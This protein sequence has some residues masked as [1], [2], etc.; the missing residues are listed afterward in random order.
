[1]SADGAGL[2]HDRGTLSEL[3]GPK[4]ARR[5]PWW[6]P[7]DTKHP[8]LREGIENAAEQ[9]FKLLAWPGLALH[10]GELD[11]KLSGYGAAAATGHSSDASGETAALHSGEV[12]DLGCPPMKLEAFLTKWLNKGGAE[13]ANKDSFLRDFCDVLGVEGPPPAGGD[14]AG[15]AYGFEH[16]VT[17]VDVDGTRRPGFIDLYKEGCFILEAK[18][19][20]MRGTSR[21]G[22]AWRDSDRWVREM[23]AAR[24]QALSYATTFAKP[25]PF[26]IVVD[27]GHCFD[28]YAN[29]EGNQSYTPFP[30]PKQARIALGDLGQHLDLFRAIFNTPHSLDPSKHAAKVTRKVAEALAELAKQLEDAGHAGEPLARFL[31]RC[32]FT[33]F[34]EDVGLLPDYL[35]TRAIEDH[36]LPHP[37]RFV[38]GIGAL[39]RAMNT[40]DHYGPLG[41]LLE[42]NGG[43]FRDAEAIELNRAQLDL[44]HSAAKSDWSQVDP[45]IFGTL[46]E[47]ALDPKER[48]KLGAHYTPRAYVERLVKPT[49]EEPLRE[50]WNE[51]QLD[52]RR[53]LKAADDGRTE[54]LARARRA[55][56]IRALHAF[57]KRLATLRV[58]DPACGTGNFLYVAL[59][60]LKR[61]E[62]EVLVQL[63]ELGETQQGLELEGLRVT[64]Q[65][66][67]GI[68]V[69]PWAK[70]IAELVLW[71][72]YLQWHFRTY[73][74]T[75]MPEPVLRD[76][77][78]IE[79]RDAVLAWDGEPVPRVDENGRPVTR[80]DGESTKPDPVTGR[81]VPDESK[82]VAIYD[83]TNPRPAE[84]PKADFIV[85]NPP[86]L[87]NKRMRAALGDGYVEAL[88]SSW[89][90]G[91]SAAWR[92][93]GN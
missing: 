54:K 79:C 85:G 68:E 20:A 50:E 51:V 86:F 63:E 88:R 57:Q 23:N 21:M 62:G 38:G 30:A 69:K 13:R 58:L 18:Q 91:A 76:Y 16:P 27:I 43:L 26:L 77:K 29:F 60:V 49:L 15:E 19:G 11:D 67:L 31:M 25:P 52:V 89:P 41:K 42:F 9:A 74:K 44:L 6:P 72:G 5:G 90:R 78:N 24:A 47:R 34:A 56:A 83:Y 39:W 14:R 93:H 92:Q 48:H 82:R 28:L 22:T 7:G 17:F 36:W 37:K 10:A 59:D 61:I 33:M 35:F 4:E 75:A 64:P 70:E 32:L 87:G 12:C 55:E 71:L 80:W 1:M 53:L 8:P 46:L 81:Q 45:A 3:R 84:W 66:F 2:G 73:G 40:G 65:Q